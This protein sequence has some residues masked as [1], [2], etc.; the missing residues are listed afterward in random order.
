MKP[1]YTW[2]AVLVGSVIA[3]IALGLFLL[4]SHLP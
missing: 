4:S 3:S 1:D 2:F